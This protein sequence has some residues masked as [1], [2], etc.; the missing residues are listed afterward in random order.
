MCEPTHS[1]VQYPMDYDD[2]NLPF[3]HHIDQE[4]RL[5]AAIKGAWGKTLGRWFHFSKVGS[6]HSGAVRL[7]GQQTLML[8]RETKYEG[9]WWERNFILD[10]VKTMR[11]SDAF[12]C[13]KEYHDRSCMGSLSLFRRFL[14]QSMLSSTRS[15][16]YV[17]L[18]LA[19]VLNRK[20]RDLV[21]GKLKKV[22]GARCTNPVKVGFGRRV[23]ERR[24]KQSID[25]VMGFTRKRNLYLPHFA[26]DDSLWV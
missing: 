7:T 21:L 26:D 23:S 10:G 6:G 20:G 17:D 19:Q 16:I 25:C 11:G 3:G 8:P 13:A 9:I 2:S 24:K 18:L 22:L 15:F 4:S 14:E 12:A 1:I 5:K